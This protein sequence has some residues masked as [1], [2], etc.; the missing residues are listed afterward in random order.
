MTALPHYLQPFVDWLRLHPHWAGLAIFGVALIESFPVIGSLVP[1]SVCMTAIGGLIGFKVIPLFSTLICAI[2]GAIIGDACSF[3]LGFHYQNRLRRYW[4][5]KRF[6]HLLKKGELFF[7]RHGGKSIFF[8]RFIGPL[9]AFVPIIAGMMNL[10]VKRYLCVN[11]VSACFWAPT[12]IAPG[13][14]LGVISQTL[15]PKVA[16]RLLIWVV[17]ILIVIWATGWLLRYLACCIF[18]FIDHGSKHIY[19]RTLIHSPLCQIIFR[20]ADGDRFTHHQLTKCFFAFICFLL[21]GSLAHAVIQKQPFLIEI[22]H[23]IWHT[24]HYFHYPSLTQIF[25]TITNLGDTDAMVTLASLFALYCLM[26]KQK[27][28]ACYTIGL[29]IIGGGITELL[30]TWIHYP[31]PGD[32]SDLV[33]N[34]SFPSGHTLL[35]T[36]TYGAIAYWLAQSNKRLA[37]YAATIIVSVIALSRLYL[38]VHWFTDI[39]GAILLGLGCLIIFNF[40]LKRQVTDQTIFWKTWLVIIASITLSWS[41][42][43]YHHYTKYMDH[44]SKPNTKKRHLP[45]K[46]V[47][48]HRIAKSAI[49]LSL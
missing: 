5:F 35:S 20:H 2:I 18:T 43:L 39:V 28:Y 45:R 11:V 26:K 29:F 32:F 49:H 46:I 36:I 23:A 13:F 22:N 16:L 21:F 8:A 40:L 15:P 31:R 6:P 48:L 37:Y 9:R 47:R 38:G 10:N 30:K 44:F 1:G 12:Y 25:I 41:V 4:P 42:G 27:H 14:L 24:F 19:Q 17:M 34:A 3:F 7:E 33:S